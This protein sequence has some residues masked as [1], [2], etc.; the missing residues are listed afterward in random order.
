MEFGV[1]PDMR[2]LP[3]ELAKFNF[4]RAVQI[5]DPSL[6][7]LTEPNVVHVR[8]TDKGIMIEFHRESFHGSWHF[9]GE[10]VTLRRLESR[11][12]KAPQMPE[13][14]PPDLGSEFPQNN[15]ED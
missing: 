5:G 7:S 15:V 6:V 14:R 4:E 8:I 11:S 3:Q 13:W 9:G 12:R 1:S 2:G 10:Q